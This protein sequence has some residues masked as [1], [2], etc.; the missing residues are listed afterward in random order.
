[1]R[2]KLRRLR[3]ADAAFLV[4]LLNQP[5]WLEFIGDRNVHS[6][7]QA[8][9][10]LAQRIDA[11]FERFGYGM[12][13]VELREPAHRARATGQPATGRPMTGPPVTDPHMTGPPMTGPPMIGPPMIGPPM[14]GPLIGLVGLVKRDS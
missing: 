10:Y 2:L 12:W 7:A 4:E 6:V 14:I 8:C 13:G 5:G 3:T 11:Q 1:E 9:D